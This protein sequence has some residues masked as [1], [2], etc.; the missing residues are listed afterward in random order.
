V[1]QKNKDEASLWIA[2]G[3]K[4]QNSSLIVFIFFDLSFSP[5]SHCSFVCGCFV[6]RLQPFL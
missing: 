4:V 3:A 5:V 1:L 2:A 6:A